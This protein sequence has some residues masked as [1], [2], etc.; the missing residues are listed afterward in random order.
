MIIS[1]LSHLSLLLVPASMPI[2]PSFAEKPTYQSR[3]ATHLRS[4]LDKPMTPSAV[5]RATGSEIPGHNLPYMAA[6]SDVVLES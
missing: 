5:I 3:Q 1:P 6:V 2:I 4:G